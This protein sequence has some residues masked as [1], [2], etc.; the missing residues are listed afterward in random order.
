ML[1]KIVGYVPLESPKSRCT[2]VQHEIKTRIFEEIETS[3]PDFYRIVVDSNLLYH[4]TFLQ[5]EVNRQQSLVIDFI[6]TLCMLHHVK[7]KTFVGDEQA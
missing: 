2:I 1:K 4:G 7:S 3:D 5:D 6:Q